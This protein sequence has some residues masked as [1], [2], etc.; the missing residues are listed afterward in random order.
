M[1]SDGQETSDVI[2]AN[3]AL[4]SPYN[5]ESCIYIDCHTVHVRWISLKGSQRK[6]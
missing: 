2:G 3:V 6:A 4:D 5:N 1:P